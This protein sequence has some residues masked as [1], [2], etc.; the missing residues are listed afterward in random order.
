M[1]E[2]IHSC[3]FALSLDL[4]AF[5]YLLLDTMEDGYWDC[6]KKMFNEVIEE[7]VPLRKVRVREHSLP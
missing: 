1:T 6:W 5:T 3:K 4:S 2:L 7:H